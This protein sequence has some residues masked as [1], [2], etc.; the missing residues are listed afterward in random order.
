MIIF[1]TYAIAIIIIMENYL[2][3]WKNASACLAR[4]DGLNEIAL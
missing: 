2:A 4:N 1:F 3:K